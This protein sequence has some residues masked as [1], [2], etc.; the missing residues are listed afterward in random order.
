MEIGKF[1]SASGLSVD[2]LRHYD[3]VG[4]LKPALVDPRTSYRRYGVDQLGDA[5]RIC[6][7]RGVDL[8]VGEVGAVLQAG[9]D[10]ELVHQILERHRTRLAQ[11]A[12]A[13]DKMMATSE[14]LTDQGVPVPPP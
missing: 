3:K 6:L 13:L 12:S 9:E 5:R 2:A 1:A 8:P 14:A 10:S 4:I 11:R 7:L